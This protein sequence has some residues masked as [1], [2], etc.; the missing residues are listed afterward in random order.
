MATPHPLKYT[1]VC[2]GEDELPQNHFI[3]GASKLESRQQSTYQTRDRKDI[4]F[5]VH[6]D[7]TQKKDIQKI[8]KNDKNS[9]QKILE[10]MASDLSG[11]VES[12]F[13]TG[14]LVRIHTYKYRLC[15]KKVFSQF[16]QVPKA[17]TG[18]LNF[19]QKYPDYDGRDVTIAIFDSGVDPRATGLEVSFRQS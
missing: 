8:I 9:E 13:P 14:A 7:Q 15:I 3:K 2:K 4:I 11:I 10:N 1:Y 16:R 18:V 19:L 6:I 17:E 5:E 12:S